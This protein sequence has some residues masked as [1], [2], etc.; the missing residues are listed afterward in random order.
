MAP[1]PDGLLSGPLS[2]AGTW[3]ILL[4]VRCCD[5]RPVFLPK[6]RV[7]RHYR[8]V[9]RNGRVLLAS[10]RGLASW[11]RATSPACNQPL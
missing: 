10:D 5:V 2:R 7:G 4:R 1:P 9:A 3:P 8:A 6:G 11:N